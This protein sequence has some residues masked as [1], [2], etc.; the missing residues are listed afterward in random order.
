MIDNKELLTIIGPW[1]KEHHPEKYEA[2]LKQVAKPKVF[3]NYMIRLVE[4]RA[5][6]PDGNAFVS[7]LPVSLL[8]ETAIKRTLTV[9]STGEKFVV[10]GKGYEGSADL[11]WTMLDA[12]PEDFAVLT[13]AIKGLD[14]EVVR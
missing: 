12:A 2:T 7:T 8:D 1:A 11:T 6:G 9:R 10:A 13:A 14:L 3:R 4:I 5:A